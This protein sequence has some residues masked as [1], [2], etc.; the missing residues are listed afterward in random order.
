MKSTLLTN[1]QARM[2][3]SQNACRV[4][5]D[6]MGPSCRRRF[7][8]QIY[9]QDLTIMVIIYTASVCSL[10]IDLWDHYTRAFGDH[11]L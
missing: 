2:L 4:K 3:S 11:D 9:T 5:A 10:S 8:L 1:M 6:D 7:L